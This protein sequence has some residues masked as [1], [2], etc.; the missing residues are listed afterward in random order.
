[1]GFHIKQHALLLIHC[2]RFLPLEQLM[3]LLDCILSLV[4]NTLIIYNFAL[5]A[6]VPLGGMIYYL[7][8]VLCF[9]MRKI[10]NLIWKTLL[11]S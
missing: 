10:F 2:R 3:G 7:V 1:M 6:G 8:G 5:L 11:S 4:L 9:E